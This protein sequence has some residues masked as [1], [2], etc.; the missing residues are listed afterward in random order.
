MVDTPFRMWAEEDRI[1]KFDTFFGPGLYSEVIKVSSEDK[2]VGIKL[3]TGARPAAPAPA[4]VS[5]RTVT[6]LEIV[7]SII[8]G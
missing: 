7:L 4:G 6:Y 2:M 1:K 8:F 5:N 3:T